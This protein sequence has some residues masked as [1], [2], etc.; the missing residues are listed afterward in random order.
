MITQCKNTCRHNTSTHDPRGFMTLYLP[1]GNT[2]FQ[3]T[4]AFFQKTP[5]TTDEKRTT[6]G[7]RVRECYWL[8]GTALGWELSSSATGLADNECSITEEPWI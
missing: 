2:R 1:D 6:R 7:W 8:M 4:A 5:T 3:P